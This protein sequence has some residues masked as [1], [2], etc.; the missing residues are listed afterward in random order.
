MPEH[1]PPA[2]GAEGPPAALLTA[3]TVA[4]GALVANLYYA[5]PLVASIAPD[6]GVTP[7]LAGSVVSV[8]Q[9]GYG[10]GLLLLV[11]LA[12][13]VENRVLVLLS[14]TCTAVGLAGVA[15]STTAMP[16]FLCAFFIGL[17]ATGAQVLLPFVTHLVP[18]HRRGRVLGN[19]MAGVL[20]GI[21][22][23]RP[24]A[25][26]VA[27]SLGWRAVFWAS[28][29]LMIAILAVLW[30]MMP[31]H[32]P[33]GRMHYGRMLASMAQLFRTR[34]DV[35][36]RAFC[37]ALMF[38]AFNLFWT[39]GPLM[40]AERFGLNNRQIGWFALAGAGGALA[41]PLVGRI[42]D[43]GFGPLASAL[44]MAA[45]ALCFLLSL[46]AVDAR[47][48][49]ALV[50]LAIIIDAGVQTNQVVSQRVVFLVPPEMRGRANALF[51]TTVFV[52]GASG[53]TLATIA[54]HAGGWAATAGAGAA[55]GAAALL[56]LALERHF[57]GKG[58]ER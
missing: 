28:A 40:L 17:C 36:W 49:I 21:M 51:M 33:S 16:F 39:A 57:D 55:A 50:L 52:G 34:S 4:T 15:L 14:L 31:R 48:L 20:T 18:E 42:A 47:A 29:V 44:S 58:A 7:D 3:I 26:F 46:W 22:L 11:P 25:L 24:A 5:Q 10:L 35:R 53:S 56:L 54:W 30:L 43:R 45:L 8:T 23:A 9:I 37:Q 2:A 32:R 13:L 38:C 6:I 1:K 12:D 27:A 19:I 41:A